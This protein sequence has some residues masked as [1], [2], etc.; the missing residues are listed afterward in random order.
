MED[1]VGIPEDLRCKRSDGKQWRCSALSMPDKTVC[2]KHYIQ[3]KRRAMNSAM[4]ANMR[5]ASKR[6]SLDNSDIYL[7]SRRREREVSRSSMSPAN[8]V[9]ESASM[10]SLKKHKDRVTKSRGFYSSAGVRGGS[11]HRGGLQQRDAVPVDGSRVQP[12]YYTPPSSKEMKNFSVDGVGDYSGKSS[13]SSGEAEGITCHHC[14]RNYRTNV[15]WC[16]SCDR[17]GYCDGCILKWY[18]EIPIED[19]QKACPACRGICNCRVC[20]RGDNLIKAKVESIAAIDRLRYLHSLLAFILP[21]LK[22]IYSEQCF[23]ISI[24][25]RIYGIKADIPREKINADQQMRCDLC[26]IP[27]FDYHRHCTQCMYDLCLTCCRDIRHASLISDKGESAADKA[28]NDE[29][30]PRSA[31]VG[32]LDFTGLFPKWKVNSDG[33]IPCG[34]DEAGGCGFSKLILRRILKINWTG[35]LLKNAEEMVNGCVGSDLHGPDRCVSYCTGTPNSSLKGS[36]QTDLLK[37]SSRDD[38]SDNF[39]YYPASEDIKLEGINRFHKFWVKGQPVIVKNVL[40][41]SLASGWEPKDIWK[42]VQET[43]DEEMNENDVVVKAIDY[44]SQSEVDIELSQFIKG[45]SKGFKDES[46][47]PK[48]LKLKDWPPP[49][50]LEEFLLC[51][52]PEFLSNFPLVEFIHSKWGLLNLVSKL[53]HDTLQSEAVP[54]IFITYGTCKELGRGDP[55]TKL[56]INMSDMA[57][58]LMHTAEPDSGGYQRSI[59]ERHDKL[60]GKSEECN[61]AGGSGR[62]DLCKF[63]GEVDYQSYSGNGVNFLEKKRNE[64]VLLIGN[65]A[66]NHDK[67]GTIW[68]IFRRQDVPKLNEFF[69]VHSDNFANS[70]TLPVYDQALYLNNETKRKLKDEFSVE[71]WTFQQHV[72]EAVFIPAGCP[73][74]VR[75]LQSSVQLAFDFLSPES[76][77]E[78]VRMAQEI[79]CLPSDHEAKLKML[80]VEKMSLYAA[81]SAVRE[82]HKIAL[83]PKLSSEIKFEEKR[84]TEMVS[85]NL[86]RISKRRRQ[87]ACP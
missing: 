14:Q 52:R 7:E 43:L 19:I 8:R 24:E 5:K 9:G 32:G 76:L 60:L 20:L 57:C 2:E 41:R 70:A 45:Y 16:T 21:V 64:A 82:V 42:G 12:V 72:G 1:N 55:V 27:I 67:A 62:I 15:V 25:K 48:M 80:E 78:S 28:Y 84:L 81:S 3:A 68:D 26:K 77:G 33:S 87:I 50:A 71:P 31:D 22:Q 74:Q 69:R 37:C 53:P 51:H 79:R 47:C 40:E 4:R 59:V 63:A 10:P 86:E 44:L 11:P 83:D 35:K 49:S 75:N 54:K 30:M 34:P 39:L 17:K 23:E 73:F 6:K 13:D 56:Q 65:S 85:E 66:K 29:L 38:S 36:F 61:P 58:L 46:G 18:A